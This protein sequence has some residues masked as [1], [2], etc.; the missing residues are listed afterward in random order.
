MADGI[1]LVNAQGAGFVPPNPNAYNLPGPMRSA[2]E[3]LL[4]GLE[5]LDKKVTDYTEDQFKEGMFDQFADKVDNDWRL[6]KYSY[7]MGAKYASA[8]QQLAELNVD[9]QDIVNKNISEGK[10]VEETLQA[11]REKQSGLRA[12]AEDLQGSYPSA[13]ENLINA[14]V[15]QQGKASEN[16]AL[17]R[18]QKRNDNIVAGNQANVYT[19]L[20]QLSE[21]NNGRVT[22][23]AIK[24]LYIELAP[25]LHESAIAM[26]VTDYN[27][28]AQNVWG[29]AIQTSLMGGK[30]TDGKYVNFINSLKESMQEGLKT[31]DIPMEMGSKLL[32]TAFQKIGEI[33]HAIEADIVLAMGNPANY[34]NQDGLNQLNRKI[35]YYE[36]VGGDPMFIA[37]ARVDIGTTLNKQTSTARKIASGAPF[38]T[39]AERQA[40]EASVMDKHFKEQNGSPEYIPLAEEEMFREYTL[41]SDVTNATKHAHNIEDMLHASITKEGKFSNTAATALAVVGRIFSYPDTGTDDYGRNNNGVIL[42]N[43]FRQSFRDKKM[44][45]FLEHNTNM[46][47][48]KLL[49]VSKLPIE[50][51]NDAAATVISDLNQQ[52]MTSY[53]SSVGDT[54]T[55]LKVEDLTS[56]IPTVG[57]NDTMAG[58]M[59]DI[60]NKN[61][62]TIQM[63]AASKGITNIA[64]DDSKGFLERE[65]YITQTK[66]GSTFVTPVGEEAIF[67]DKV[68]DRVA[69]FAAID[70]L[71]QETRVANPDG[72]YTVR[73]KSSTSEAFLSYDPDSKCFYRHYTSDNGV[74]ISTPVT[75]DEFKLEMAKHR[76][77]IDETSKKINKMSTVAS[78]D[79]EVFR[80]NRYVGTVEEALRDVPKD[81]P[82]TDTTEGYGATVGTPTAPEMPIEEDS[83]YGT[84]YLSGTGSRLFKGKAPDEVDAITRNNFL[85]YLA[86][87]TQDSGISDSARKSARKLLNVEP[88]AVIGSAPFNDLS[89]KYWDR[90]QQDMSEEKGVNED[91]TAIHKATGINPDSEYGRAVADYK[92]NTLGVPV[93]FSK[94]DERLTNPSA[95]ATTINGEDFTGVKGIRVYREGDKEGIFIVPEELK[96]LNRED[97]LKF[98]SKVFYNTKNEACNDL[99]V[100]NFGPYSHSF[101]WG[102]K[103]KANAGVYLTSDAFDGVIPDRLMPVVNRRQFAKGKFSWFSNNHDNKAVARN[104]SA[105]S[106]DEVFDLL[107]SSNDVLAM[108]ATRSK[109]LKE[110]Y[111]GM[112]ETMQAH[113]GVDLS[114]ERDN[115]AYDPVF[116]FLG[117]TCSSGSV[118]TDTAYK[119]MFWAMQGNSEMAHWMLSSGGYK[120]YDNSSNARKNVLTSDVN[121][122]I[123]L[124]RAGVFDEH[125][126]TMKQDEESWNTMRNRNKS[127]KEISTL[128]EQQSKAYL[129]LKRKNN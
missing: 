129:Y 24:D 111:N 54:L 67:G 5:F 126:D 77:A 122:V 93:V 73:G 7:D 81:L 85:E 28:Y 102:D 123:A 84:K 15:K 99:R 25:E 26:G 76:A 10:S 50:V 17:M 14:L 116:V 58:A 12:I 79:E 68:A 109:Y 124:A 48:S 63:T 64:K 18:I 1:K 103:N 118:D 36:S 86:N 35:N 20:Q 88:M 110:Q 56:W 89:I 128:E 16:V 22:P 101:T 66:S 41:R 92:V 3:S 90:F 69:Y 106:S 37:R 107:T 83:F 44:L 104:N 75:L 34:T 113:S 9:V 47:A 125:F 52:W 61:R 40:F 2:S 117:D 19:R 82:A 39:A 62:F 94:Y 43:A 98:M 27:A 87:A 95:E 46:F 105:R 31:G 30:A 91:F 80:Q 70:T 114:K 13:A 23:E 72:T 74:G 29:S 45:A 121:S 42:R 97:K 11:V 59:T 4:K 78:Y 112:V 33:H 65:G 96:K 108:S 127:T 60:I 71:T 49:E 57:F 119:I 55:G 8:Q 32:T 51:R 6:G 120:E 53:N 21:E 115:A 100:L 38:T